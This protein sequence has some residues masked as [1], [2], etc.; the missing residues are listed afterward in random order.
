MP[1]KD[2]DFQ[3]E[4]AAKA[5]RSATGGASTMTDPADPRK[6]ADERKAALA[7]AVANAVARGARVESQSDY[8]AVVVYGKRV[9]HVLHAI[10]SIFTLLFWV[11][12]WVLLVVTGGEKR[13][14]IQVDEFGNV[15]VQKV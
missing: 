13:N 15:N 5:E 3:T 7:Q 8:Q 12:V 9:N 1:G 2:F 4:L 10:L 14:L 6:T 11:I